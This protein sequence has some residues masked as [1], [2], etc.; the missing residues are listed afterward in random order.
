MA[1]TRAARLAIPCGV[2]IER[3][4]VAWSVVSRDALSA[5]STMM[6][7]FVLAVITLRLEAQLCTHRL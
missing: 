6:L 4:G 5:F 3:E 2:L 1:P 7:K